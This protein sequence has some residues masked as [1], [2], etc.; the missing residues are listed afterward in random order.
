MIVFYRTVY[1]WIKV[2]GLQTYKKLKPQDEIIVELDKMW[3]HL[4]K[5][6]TN[7]ISRKHLVEGVYR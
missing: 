2:F 3:L 1:K 6:R 7:Y 5:K 4:T